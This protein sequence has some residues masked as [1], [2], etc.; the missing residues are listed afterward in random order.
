MMAAAMV[1][2]A[3]HTLM[4]RHGKAVFVSYYLSALPICGRAPECAHTR[5][6]PCRHCGGPSAGWRRGDQPGFC[7]RRAHAR[8]RDR[9]C[10][11]DHPKPGLRCRQQGV[12]ILPSHVIAQEIGHHVQL[13]SVYDRFEIG[14]CCEPRLNSSDGSVTEDTTSDLALASCGPAFPLL[15]LAV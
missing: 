15:A 1:F 7:C 9:E 5:V 6:D 14:K 4:P 11:E 13:G 2:G 12:S 3:V 8:V 10:R